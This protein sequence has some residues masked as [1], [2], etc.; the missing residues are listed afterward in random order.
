VTFRQRRFRWQVEGQVSASRGDALHAIG[1][2]NKLP[3]GTCRISVHDVRI[4]QHLY[5]AIQEYGGFS[6]PEWLD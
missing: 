3:Y 2:T 5:G 6:R 1:C 4:A